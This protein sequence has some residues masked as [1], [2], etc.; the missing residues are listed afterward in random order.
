[1]SWQIPVQKLELDRLREGQPK[2]WVFEHVPPDRMNTLHRHLKELVGVVEA[3]GTRIILSTHVSR[4]GDSLTTA[5]ERHL[6]GANRFY[7]RAS[8][9]ALLEV[10][11]AAN[12]AIRQVAQEMNVPLVEMTAQIP[13]S[14][15]YFADAS[16][17]TDE[18]AHRAAQAFVDV[19][20]HALHREDAAIVDQ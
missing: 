7:P 13:P 11:S 6:L 12:K 14:D 15:K 17:F 20:L 5:D 8:E 16:H 10:D 4:F 19:L 9:E 18:G 2:D 3:S 1:M